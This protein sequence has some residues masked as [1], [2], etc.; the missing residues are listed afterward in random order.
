M[1]ILQFR[2]DTKED[3]ELFTINTST[4]NS[5]IPPSL[6]LRIKQSSN[7]REDEKNTKIKSLLLFYLEN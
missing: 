2:D 4:F 7:V 1:H 3:Q 6:R 5:T